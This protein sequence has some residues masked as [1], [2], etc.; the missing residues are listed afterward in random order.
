MLLKI[1]ENGDHFRDVMIQEGET[2]L[3]PGTMPEYL[4]P[5]CNH[6]AYQNLISTGNTPHSP[7]RYKDTIGLV[8]E[9]T[10]P[11]RSMDRIRWYCSNKDGHPGAASIIREE[12]FHCENIETQLKDVID[13]WMGNESSRKCSGCGVIAPAC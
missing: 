5:G 3:V 13:D 12:T 11:P 7:I 8:M 4:S 2:F 6:Y 10:R 9:R 1:V